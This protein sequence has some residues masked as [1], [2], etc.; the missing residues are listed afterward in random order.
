MRLKGKRTAKRRLCALEVPC[1]AARE[2]ELVVGLGVARIERRGPLE[3]FARLRRASGLEQGLAV[4]EAVRRVLGVDCNRPAY[5]FQ[6]RCLVAALRAQDPETVH[7]VG[8][9]R[10]ALQYFPVETLGFGQVALGVQIPGALQRSLDVH[11]SPRGRPLRG[12]RKTRPVAM[13]VFS[14][15]PAGTGRVGAHRHGQTEANASRICWIVAR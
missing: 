10:R 2:A 6:S 8:V 4:V 15:A 9:A 14:P 1:L 5:P 3:S 13:L 7:G 11:G 12:S